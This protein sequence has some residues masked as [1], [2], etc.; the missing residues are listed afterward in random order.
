MRGGG[1]GVIA[2]IILIYWMYEDGRILLSKNLLSFFFCMFLPVFT[3][4]QLFC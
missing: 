4:S 3:L 2:K 1:L